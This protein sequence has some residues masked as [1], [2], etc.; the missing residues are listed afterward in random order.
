MGPRRRV[1]RCGALVAL[2]PRQGK[3]GRGVTNRNTTD[4]HAIVCAVTGDHAFALASLVV[5]FRRHNPA[6]AGAFVVFHDGL[7]DVQQAQLRVLWP[8]MVFRPFGADVL[9]A[10]FGDGVNLAATLARVS[11]MIF[12]KFEM[13]D[14]LAEYDKCLW[15]DVD[16]LVQGD[17]AEVWAFDVLAW[18]P[19]PRGA[20]ARRAE[21]MAAF[22]DMCGDGALP[23]LNG[24]VVGMGR[25]LPITTADLYAMA[26]R[27]MSQTSTP[28]VDELALYFLAAARGVAV[29]L[30]DL[31]F[32]HPVVA[33]G[34]RD[35]VVVHAIGPDK[36]WNAAPLQL[37]YPDWARNVLGW[38]GAG[39]DGPQRLGDVQAA[40]P[41]AA[42]KAAR[43]RAY[44]RQVYSAIRAGLPMGLQV[45]LDSDDG[46]LRFF[47]GAGAP[48]RLIRQA[49][50]RRI[51]VEL[52]FA[53]D[54]T[55]APAIFAQME[56]AQVPGLTK[57]KTLD[58][59]QTA[60]GWAYTAVVPVDLCV[61]V[62]GVF[63]AVLD[64][65]T[66]RAKS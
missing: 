66:S 14:L 24:G 4:G 44:W 21:A 17:M 36:F 16:M 3:R 49:N 58:L 13:A 43:N 32:N 42:L 9:R 6:Y 29:H 41:D 46:A 56:A 26:A 50:A 51:G 64:Q 15:L 31:R 65:A 61:Q 8:A 54:A 5:G 60:Q 38:A 12:A 37:A 27:V 25:G 2:W 20:F 39:F 48:V 35:A 18:R 40:T 1:E 57:G 52:R 30:L 53:D 23:L 19:L 62:M 63:V 34:G 10:R 22:A 45:D 33:P 28:S 59:A 11:P 7:T 47:Y 55:L